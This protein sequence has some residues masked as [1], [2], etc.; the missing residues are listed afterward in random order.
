MP[1]AVDLKDLI[2]TVQ[3]GPHKQTL[4]EEQARLWTFTV[5]LKS[6]NIYNIYLFM[7]SLTAAI[8]SQATA[9][10]VYAPSP[11]SQLWCVLAAVY[12]LR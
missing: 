7:K 3:Y 2:S 12:L 4:P 9:V 8:C 5:V 1:T 6:K 10:I 11:T